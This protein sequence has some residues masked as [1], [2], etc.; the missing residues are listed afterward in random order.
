MARNGH[1]TGILAAACAARGIDLVARLDE[2][3]LRRL[4]TDGS[5]TAPSDPPSPAQSVWRVEARGRAR[6]PPTRSTAAPG[7][8]AL[9]IARTAWLFGPPGGDFP[10]RILEA[11]ERARPPA[12]RSARSATSGGR[13]HIRPTSPT[14]SS[15]CSRTTPMPGSTTSSTACSRPAPTGPR[16]SSPAPASTS[17]SSTCPGIDL[18]A[19][20]G[21]AALGRA[22][23]HA[24]PVRRADPHLARRD[25]RLRAASCPGMA[26]RVT[27]AEAANAR[28]RRCPASATAQAPGSPTP[29]ARSSSCGARTPTRPSIR[30]TPARRPAGRPGSSRPTCP[31]RAQGSLRGLHLHRRQCDLWIVAE[32]AR[33]RRARRRPADA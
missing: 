3:G 27:W 29:A 18:G 24:P 14:R 28:R 10:S 32:R 13:R 1:A 7:P 15:S 33:L 8:A 5:A 22:G 17:R 6:W 19:P 21:A 11:A 9:G 31:R 20:V 25:G 23:G 2:R 4:R 12:S 16:T 30:G 26:G